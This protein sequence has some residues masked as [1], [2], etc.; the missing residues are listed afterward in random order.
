MFSFLST[1]E[2]YQIINVH[3][4]AVLCKPTPLFQPAWLTFIYFLIL[5]KGYQFC[6]ELMRPGW[7]YFL[8]KTSMRQISTVNYPTKYMMEGMTIPVLACKA[9]NL[10]IN[11]AQTIKSSLQKQSSHLGVKIL[12]RFENVWSENPNSTISHQ[13]TNQIRWILLLQDVPSATKRFVSP[14][15]DAS[16][17]QPQPF[18]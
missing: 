2:P 9:L 14:H 15:S 17:S 6:C 8:S 7:F 18:T 11:S 12:F 3:G 5:I 4:T 10:L 16:A 13:A 1:S